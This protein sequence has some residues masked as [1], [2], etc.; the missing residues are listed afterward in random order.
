[1]DRPQIS[2]SLVTALALTA[3]L[4]ITA[5]T[6]GPDFVRPA[7]PAP[8]S[9]QVFGSGDDSLRAAT[10]RQSSPLPSRWW[11]AFSDPALNRLVDEALTANA[12]LK[13]AALR[14]AQARLVRDNESS[15]D[16]AEAHAVA[17]SSRQRQSEY[18][19]N[20]RVLDIIGA[21]DRDRLASALSGPFSVT[22]AGVDV[23]WEPDF[24]GGVRRAV[25]AADADVARQGALLDLA[26]LSIS[27]EVA[28]TYL[29]MRTAQ[30]QLQLLRQEIT[31]LEEKVGLLEARAHG[32]LLD[33]VELQRQN[34]DLQA[35]RAEVP[36]LL[37]QESAN[38]SQLTLLVGRS[39]RGL[40]ET[41]VSEASGVGRL[42]IVDLSLGLPSEVAL[43]RPDIRSA[44]ALLHRATA[45]IGVARAQLYPSVRLGAKVGLDSYRQGELADWGSRTWS[46]GPSL[47]LPLFDNG[48]RQRVVQL[49]ELEQQEA[50]INYQFTVLKAWKEIDDALTGFDADR[51]QLK[52]LRQR[53][54]IALD[55]FELSRSRYASGIVDYAAVL[56]A[57][58]GLLQARKAAVMCEGRLWSRFVVV[59]KAL[60]NTPST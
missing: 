52:S 9:W 31:G 47:D 50:A 39:P 51:Q 48:R 44:E 36:A 58:R 11:E 24:W 37:A 1:M 54:D 15:N 23:S 46:I 19:A 33:H 14:V 30:R 57:Q 13:T 2:S 22:Q 26:R 27:G 7:S 34:A 38:A 42:E 28:R 45:A 20:T 25:E 3:V 56:D 53:Q 29:E 5:C 16:Q 17:G 8:S 43:R 21:G 49:R 59:N 40:R 6:S 12:D 4:A 18:S 10:A 32:G 55:A 41:L 35:L 60:G